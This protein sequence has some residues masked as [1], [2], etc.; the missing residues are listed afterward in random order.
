VKSVI[1]SLC[2]QHIGVVVAGYL[3]FYVGKRHGESKHPNCKTILLYLIHRVKFIGVKAK[4][5]YRFV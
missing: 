2:T 5:R 4:T 3:C 1:F